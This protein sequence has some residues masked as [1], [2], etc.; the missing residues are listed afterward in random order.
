MIARIVIWDLG[1]YVNTMQEM[2][3]VVFLPPAYCYY[4]GG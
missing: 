4:T 3:T 2:L 1:F